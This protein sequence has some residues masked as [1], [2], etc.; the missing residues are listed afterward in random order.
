MKYFEQSRYYISSYTYEC[1]IITAGR[2]GDVKLISSL[3]SAA[4]KKNGKTCALRDALLHAYRVCDAHQRLISTTY[5]L[6]TDHVSITSVQYE[7]ILRTL[8]AHSEYDSLCEHIVLKMKEQ[9]R[10]ISLPVLSIL[11]N[12][13][14]VRSPRLTVLLINQT[15]FHND[16]PPLLNIILSREL[17]KFSEKKEPRGMVLIYKEMSRRKLKVNCSELSRLKRVIGE[18]MYSDYFFD[19]SDDDDVF[20]Q[21]WTQCWL[22]KNCLSEDDVCS[23]IEMVHHSKRSHVVELFEL[24][25]FVWLV[26]RTNV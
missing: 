4:V 2:I 6:F 24:F 15:R 19:I 7:D 10:M 11:L 12:S 23:F 9:N 25:K 13:L 14:D 22:E 16:N 21:L 26:Q 3:Y 1:A 17:T 18:L 8:V 5:Q 20:T